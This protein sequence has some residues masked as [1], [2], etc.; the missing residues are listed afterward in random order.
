MRRWAWGR[1]R[2]V[3]VRRFSGTAGLCVCVCV[4]PDGP[5][6]WSTLL[7]RLS[8]VMDLVSSVLIDRYRYRYLL[9]VSLLFYLPSLSLWYVYYASA[10]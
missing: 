8:L 1:G 2:G 9:L 10:S 6:F 7:N 5:H 4:N 3:A